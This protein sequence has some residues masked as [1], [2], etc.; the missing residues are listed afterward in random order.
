MTAHPSPPTPDEFYVGYFPLPAG[1]RPF[2]AAS[3]A[4]AFAFAIAVASLLAIAQRTPGDAVW[5]TSSPITLEGVLHNTPYPM[6]TPIGPN[7]GQAP[8]LLVEQGKIGAQPR[9]APFEGKVVRVTGWPLQRDGRRI[10]ELVPPDPNLQA[11]IAID[12]APDPA[13]RPQPVALGTATLRGEIVDSKCF[14]GAMKPGDGKGHKAC[15]TLCVKNGIP[16]VLVTNGPD[17]SRRYLVVTS[18][19]GGPM[20]EALV[21]FVGEPIEVTGELIE[22]GPLTLVRLAPDSAKRLGR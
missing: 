6:L 4:A 5:D 18:P 14:L 13:P 9:T 10:L 15:A 22:Q 1:H 16:A 11:I 20:L 3:L 12:G 7:A 19:E 21:P 2:V 17:G 8:A